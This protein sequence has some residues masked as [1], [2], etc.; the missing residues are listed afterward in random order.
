MI[1][2]HRLIVAVAVGASIVHGVQALPTAQAAARTWSNVMY[3][4]GAAGV[5]GKSLDWNNK[6]TIASDKITFTGKNKIRFE[7]ET[8]SVR[9]LDYTGRRHANDG[10][11]A[12]GF[13]AGGLIGMLA[14]SAVRSTDH[15][16]ELVYTLP[17]GSLGALLFRLHKENQQ[18]IIN[19]MHSVTGIE[20]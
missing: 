16:L 13:A 15:Y 9:R 18:E 19:A 17:D 2:D 7:I 3:L 5:R 12:A 1:A 6:L 10:A 20:K 4:G 14:G 8:S 11:V